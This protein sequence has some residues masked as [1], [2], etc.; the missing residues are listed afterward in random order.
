MLFTHSAVRT[1]TKYVVS[2]RYYRNFTI[3]AWSSITRLQLRDK[4]RV[5]I[6]WV[7][8][9]RGVVLGLC[10]IG[11]SPELH[12]KSKHTLARIPYIM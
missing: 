11:Q 10:I 3:I 7:T 5:L 9:L 8:S 12:I 1:N 2:I 4:L 6:P